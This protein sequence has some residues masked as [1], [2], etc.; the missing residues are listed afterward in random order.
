LANC[1]EPI[2]LWARVATF[3]DLP[4]IL[5]GGQKVKG[6]RAKLAKSAKKNT[7]RKAWS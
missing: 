3:Y 7:L 1:P 2:R 4:D 5:D 6:F